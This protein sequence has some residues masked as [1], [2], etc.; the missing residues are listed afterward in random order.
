MIIVFG[1]QPLY[2][3]TEEDLADARAAVTEAE[4][5]VA[6]AEA[7][8]ADA[9]EVLEEAK[10]ASVQA[11]AAVADAEAALAEARTALTEAENALAKAKTALAETEG[12]SA[13]TETALVTTDES[14]E[15]TGEALT[16][17]EEAEGT[18]VT[19]DMED[20]EEILAETEEAEETEEAF[21]EAPATGTEQEIPESVR[22]N[23]Y[24][25]ESE[26][27]L[28]LARE[29]YDAGDY[30]TATEYAEEAARYAKLSDDYIAGQTGG[31]QVLPATYTVR[32]WGVSRDCLWNIAGR[33]W[34]Y[35]DPHKWR[36]LYEANRSK[37]PNPNNPNLL[38]PG[39]VLDIP[40]IK[41]ETRRGKW[42]SGKAYTPLR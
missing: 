2:A 34:V 32:A 6:T 23:E 33:P 20:T 25:L 40:S 3:G 28:A 17:A 19:E 38:E 31:E 26:R 16:E 41:G 21:V 7:A 12:V 27:L 9:K 24:F 8:V 22:Y 15:E 36:V 10:A 37:L 14:P 1:I 13:E 18:E 42:E 11:Q 35:G 4:R 39:I 30:D 5:S 29:A